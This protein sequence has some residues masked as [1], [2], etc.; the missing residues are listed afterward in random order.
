M[1]NMECEKYS[2]RQV[3]L[4]LGK[5][6]VIIKTACCR[7]CY[8]VYGN[9]KQGFGVEVRWDYSTGEGEKAK[10]PPLFLSFEQAERVAKKLALEDVHPVHLLDVIHDLFV[11]EIYQWQSRDYKCS[12]RHYF[13]IDKK[14][15]D[16]YTNNTTSC[17]ITG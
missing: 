1:I 5:M 8:R 17:V 9:C 3:Q 13:V 2:R 6:L 14:Y 11:K 16:C 10:S 15:R 7:K 4:S 12:D